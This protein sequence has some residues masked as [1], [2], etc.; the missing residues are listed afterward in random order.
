LPR[1]DRFPGPDGCLPKVLFIFYHPSANSSCHCSSPW[2]FDSISCS[3]IT[4]Y[5]AIYQKTIGA[6]YSITSYTPTVH[7]LDFDVP[8]TNTTSTKPVPFTLPLSFTKSFCSLSSAIVLF[9][10]VQI[11]KCLLLHFTSTV[12]PP[13]SDQ[14]ISSSALLSHC[15]P[16]HFLFIYWFSWH[17]HGRTGINMGGLASTWEDWHQHRRTFCFTRLHYFHSKSCRHIILLSFSAHLIHLVSNVLVP[18][19]IYPEGLLVHALSYLSMCKSIRSYS[20]MSLR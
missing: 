1:S 11:K 5:L 13:R 9:L 15:I 2:D 16:S 12:F 19:H 17:Q 4:L 20:C 3:S 14:N 18:P 6:R 7:L 10:L 8:P